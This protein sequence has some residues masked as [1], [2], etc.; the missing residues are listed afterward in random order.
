MSTSVKRHAVHISL[1]H[2]RLDG[3]AVRQIHGLE[4]ISQL[5]HFDVHVVSADKL[6]DI[7]ELLGTEAHLTFERQLG[8]DETPRL[9]RTVSGVLASVR[10]RLGALQAEGTPWAYEYVM[11]VVPLLW[12]ASLTVTSDVYQELSVP[13]IVGKILEEQL[14]M[15]PGM[16]FEFKL[17]AAAYPKRDF[18]VQYEESH[19]DLIGRLCEH[20]GIFFYF[21]GRKVVFGD[22][23]EH[24]GTFTGADDAH[25]GKAFFRTRGERSHVYELQT[26]FRQ[27]PG[28][29][30]VA[31]YNFRMPAGELAAN[32][33][34]SKGSAAHVDE[35]G[36]HFKTDAEAGFIAQI[37][38]QAAAAEYE[39][40]EGKSE[41]PGFGAGMRLEVE[42]HPATERKLILTEVV[43]RAL[44]SVLGH[45]TGAEIAYENEFRMIPD[46][47]KRTFR[48][49]KLT[50]KPVV[51]GLLTAIVESADEKTLGAIDDEGQYRLNFHFDS[52]SSLAK[53]GEPIPERPPG[54]ASRAVRMAQPSAGTDRK[55]HLPLK[56]GTEVVVACVNGDPDR[57]VILGAVP[58]LRSGGKGKRYSPVTKQNKEKL[59]LKTNRSEMSVDDQEGTSHWR[60]QVDN[61]AHV[62]LIGHNEGTKPSESL[63]PAHVREDGFA[64]ASDANLTATVKEGMTFESNLLAALQQQMTVLTKDKSVEFVGEDPGWED[65]KQFEQAL[66]QADA[67]VR[68]SF[69]AAKKAAQERA[70]G[71]KQ[72]HADSHAAAAA[73]IGAEPGAD[74]E[75]ERK[76]T[77]EAHAQASAEADEACGEARKL[78][79]EEDEL[80]HRAETAKG[81]Q[82]TAEAEGKAERAAEKQWDRKRATAERRAESAANEPA[83]AA[84]RDKR[85]RATQERDWAKTRAEVHEQHGDAKAEEVRRLEAA[86]DD[87]NAERQKAEERCRAAKERRAGEEQKQQALAREHKTKDKHERAEQQAQRAEVKWK[88]VEAELAAGKKSEA[89]EGEPEQEAKPPEKKDLW[90]KI[91]KELSDTAHQTH[92]EAAQTAVGDAADSLKASTERKA[93]KAGAFV[94][95][96]GLRVAKDSIGV[97]G[98]RNAFL[99][100]DKQATVYSHAHAHLVSG[101]QA[102]VKADK[103]VE[104][105]SDDWIFITTTNVVDVECDDKI[106]LLAKGSGGL[107]MEAETASISGKAMKNIE[108]EAKMNIDMNATMQL[109]GVGTAGIDLSSPAMIGVKAGGMATYSAGGA[110][111]MS[112]GAAL[113][114][115]AGA[116]FTATAGAAFTASAGAAATVVAGAALTL[117]AG[118]AATLAAGGLV[119]IAG[120]GLLIL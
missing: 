72:A 25:A 43:H 69:E 116:A 115:S 81:E 13:E 120:S 82:R 88:K 95:P 113:T 16:D 50:R 70:A 101:D 6:L 104:I 12:K 7:H 23:N 92:L 89:K 5:F 45:G 79:A 30:R 9:E 85:D 62:L 37:R 44:Q 80:R 102:H 1:H 35:F 106:Q 71:A 22:E 11:Q 24:F 107:T 54:K 26:A 98:Q 36:G 15:E 33:K 27:L 87:K 91:A 103:G 52:R 66:V 119:T 73:A 83:R 46:E 56:H 67:Y 8:S 60:T 57:P 17:D 20:E 34:F 31:D 93:G 38:G 84:A 65:W 32:Y 110:M 4:R 117:T 53:P 39:S 21:E 14:G 99:F 94:E 105:A 100:G 90:S 77:D 42:G 18:I 29:F 112:A 114:A 97:M 76:K 109:K 64:L 49:P 28:E 75:A 96:Y 118:A 3:L 10:E 2:D 108:L 47:P 78:R 55:F 111:T 74:L 40:I 19:L 63:V 41:Y 48:P 59:V 86:I 51:S 68:L 58:D 61:W